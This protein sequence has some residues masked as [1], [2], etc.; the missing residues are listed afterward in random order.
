VGLLAALALAAT[1]CSGGGDGGGSGSAIG[2]AT[3]TSEPPPE[4]FAELR[5]PMALHLAPDGRIVVAEAGSGAD[6]GRV[7]VISSDGVDVTV[8]LD[9]LPSVAGTGEPWGDIS[10]ATGAAMAPDGTVCATIGIPD[11][12]P[13]PVSEI[14]CT[15]GLTVDL[16]A[17]EAANDPDEFGAASRAFDVVA[18]GD[19]GW[20]VSDA[21]AN[22]VL[23]VDRSGA[24]ELTGVFPTFGTFA[25]PVEGRP[26]GLFLAGESPFQAGSLGPRGGIPEYGALV[27]ALFN[28]A[29]AVVRPVDPADPGLGLADTPSAIASFASTDWLY[30][31]QYHGDA[32][33]LYDTLGRAYWRGSG[34]TGLVQ[35]ADGSFLV[36]ISA[37]G[38]IIRVGPEPLAE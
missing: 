25:T 13:A 12:A 34:G 23:H 31:L 33:G 2:G 9:G 24:V 36:A 27:V 22:T 35:L 5:N 28:G 19:D 6:D 16:A 11:T 26:L 1:A 29:L 15:D 37:E 3:P 10:G 4:A 21:A 18:D 8:V 20:W 14:R 32:A 7:S 17:W 38:R 30:V